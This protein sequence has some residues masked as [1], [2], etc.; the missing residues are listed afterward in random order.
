MT[1]PLADEAI[2]DWTRRMADVALLTASVCTG[3]FV[4]ARLGILDGRRATTHWEDIAELKAG[5]PHLDI[6]G[7]VAF[8][9]TGDVV[10]SAGIVAT[11]K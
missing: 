5:F 2:L 4:L 8:V 7:D 3:A 6:V 11:R 9:D 10:T 1:E